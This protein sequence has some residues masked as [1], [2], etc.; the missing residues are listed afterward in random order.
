MNKRRCPVKAVLYIWVAPTRF[1]S[2]C[3]IRI[4]RHLAGLHVRRLRYQVACLFARR[5]ALMHE[6]VAVPFYTGSCLPSRSLR[7]LLSF[8]SPPRELRRHL[9]EA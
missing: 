6:G 7:S 5:T 9:E 1:P 8:L 3:G 4:V 2:G